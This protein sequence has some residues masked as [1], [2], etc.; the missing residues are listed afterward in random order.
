MHLVGFITRIYHDARSPERQI[1]FIEYFYSLLSGIL[2]FRSIL[3]CYILSSLFKII[4][5][6]I[7]YLCFYVYCYF[8]LASKLYRCVCYMLGHLQKQFGTETYCVILSIFMT[9]EKITDVA[10]FTLVQ[11]SSKTY[12]YF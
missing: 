10:D 5:L 3:N 9:M 4:G 8:F 2:I 1:R 6:C 11:P 12:V 7:W